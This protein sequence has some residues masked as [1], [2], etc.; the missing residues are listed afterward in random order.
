MAI[1]ATRWAMTCGAAIPSLTVSAASELV[2]RLRRAAIVF[3]RSSV[4]RRRALL[5][6][7]VHAGAALFVREARGDHAGGERVGLLE[8]EVHLLV[9]RALA[10][11]EGRGRFGGQ[12]S[13]KIRNRLIEVFRRYHLVDQTPFHR[14]LRADGL[15]REQHLHRVLALQIAPD[16]DAG[17]G[18]E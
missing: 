1:R 7:G 6:E 17:G 15:T 9:E 8:A 10:G 4:F 16:R 5:D 2:L 3:L 13:C 12:G 11:G 14:L 18:A